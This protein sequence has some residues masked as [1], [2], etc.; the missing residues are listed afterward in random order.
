M[1]EY[2]GTQYT[3][4]DLQIEATK[5]GLDINT[6][7]NRMKNIG[8]K[9]I[10]NEQSSLNYYGGTSMY[11]YDEKQ[12][13]FGEAIDREIVNIGTRGINTFLKA[14]KGVGGYGAALER[15]ASDWYGNFINETEEEKIERLEKLKIH[16]DES[17]VMNLLEPAIEK[18]EEGYIYSEKGI[19]EQFNAGNYGAM[20][21][22]II[23]GGVE[24]IP[25]LMAAFYGIGGLTS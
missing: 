6:F 4:N 14:V 17:L 5:Q 12:G 25:S 2:N 7:V 10:S 1:F 3:L 11:E 22:Q 16:Q 19:T 8:M 20:S 24:S 23:S 9:Q 13:Y 18:L 15:S 21:R